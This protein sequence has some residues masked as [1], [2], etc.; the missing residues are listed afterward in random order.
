[1]PVFILLQN[2]DNCICGNII[3]VHIKIRQLKQRTRR[4]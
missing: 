2:S 4:Y 3:A 1:M